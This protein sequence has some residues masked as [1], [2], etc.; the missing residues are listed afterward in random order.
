[1]SDRSWA[2]ELNEQEFTIE[3]QRRFGP[4]IDVIPTRENYVN[5]QEAQYHGIDNFN[6]DDMT[7]QDKFVPENEGKHVNMVYSCRHCQKE[8]THRIAQAGHERLCKGKK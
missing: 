4:H 3:Y 2:V 8:F 6:L 1:M 7:V 5:G